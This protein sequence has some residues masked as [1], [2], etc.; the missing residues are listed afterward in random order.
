MT[1]RTWFAN[2]MDR[3]EYCP[4]CGDELVYETA[5]VV[6][7][8]RTILTNPDHTLDDKYPIAFDGHGNAYK[9]MARYECERYNQ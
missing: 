3:F 4:R 2:T 9:Y 8:P 5:N 1:G 7:Y 6:S